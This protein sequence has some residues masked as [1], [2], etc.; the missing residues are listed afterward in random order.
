MRPKGP[1][2][3]WNG[4][5][6]LKRQYTYS[7][8]NLDEA[9]TDEQFGS[10]EGNPDINPIQTPS[11]PFQDPTK[12]RKAALG[13]LFGGIASAFGLAFAIEFFLDPSLK[14]PIEIEPRSDCPCFWLYLGCDFRAAES[15]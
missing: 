14:R 1:S 3:T 2:R 6:H 4:D 10:G 9:R 5:V 12:L 8:R 11:P 7:A 15:R 13:I